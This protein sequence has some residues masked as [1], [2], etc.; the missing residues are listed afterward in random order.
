[1]WDVIEDLVREGTTLVLT[2]QY[3]EEADQLAH[4]IAVIDGGR[5]IAEGTSDELKLQVGGDRLEVVGGSPG[6]H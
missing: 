4:K 1:M 6:G 3:L 5:V 2:T